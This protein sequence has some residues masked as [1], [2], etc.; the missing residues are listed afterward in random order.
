M[1]RLNMKA[2][3]HWGT[4]VL[5]NQS[6]GSEPLWACGDQLKSWGQRPTGA[7]AGWLVVR[8]PLAANQSKHLLTTSSHASRIGFAC[9]WKAIW[10]GIWGS[11]FVSVFLQVEIPWLE[12]WLVPCHTE[13]A[14]LTTSLA[15]ATIWLTRP[16]MVWQGYEWALV[17]RGH[18]WCLN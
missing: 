17:Q 7:P 6:P 8:H 12:Q 3:P 4:N 11:F 16:T 1:P 18:G 5:A 9:T 14:L 2:V 10:I 15:M 13:S